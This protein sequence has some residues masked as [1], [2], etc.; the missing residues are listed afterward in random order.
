MTWSDLQ[1]VTQQAV[2]LGQDG[3]IRGPVQSVRAQV[4]ADA[5][6]LVGPGSAPDPVGAFHDRHGPSRA[7]GTLGSSQPGG[8]AAQHEQVDVGHGQVLVRGGTTCTASAHTRRI[9]VEGQ[10]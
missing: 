2:Q 8:A 1:I 6:D 9:V 7:N 10:G 4:D 5:G 3:R